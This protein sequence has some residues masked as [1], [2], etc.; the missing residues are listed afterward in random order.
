[1]RERS[2]MTKPGRKRP[3]AEIEALIIP[4]LVAAIYPVLIPVEP[5]DCAIQA[6]NQK[7]MMRIAQGIWWSFKQET[8][9]LEEAE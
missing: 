7:R 4:K 5:Q 1:M 9:N 3:D 2:V 6:R 8:S